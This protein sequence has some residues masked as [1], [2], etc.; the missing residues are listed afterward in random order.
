M[1]AFEFLILN[2]NARASFDFVANFKSRSLVTDFVLL[3]KCVI[4]RCRAA[5]ELSRRLPLQPAATLAW[6]TEK[7]TS[8]SAFGVCLFAQSHRRHRPFI[9][10][11]T[12]NRTVFCSLAQLA[13][14]L[15]RRS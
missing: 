2:L 8:F 9:F 6:L 3:F 4:F 10:L 13:A 7:T 12:A 5:F 15:T 14:Y 1:F 11:A